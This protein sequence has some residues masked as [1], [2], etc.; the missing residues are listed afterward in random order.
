MIG[1]P[2]SDFENLA[3]Y[4]TE[5]NDKI[6]YNFAEWVREDPSASEYEKM[7]KF[8]LMLPENFIKEVFMRNLDKLKNEEKSIILYN[9][10][11]SIQQCCLLNS[12][13]LYPHK[14][15]IFNNSKERS[16]KA[17][18]NKYFSDLEEEE[19]DKKSEQILVQY[20]E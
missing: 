2:G 15:I 8:G 12:N 4:F 11:R 1:T 19:A 7:I 10:P 17:L 6:A 20:E 5:Q 13:H 3:T 14:V 9:F 18:R 16:V